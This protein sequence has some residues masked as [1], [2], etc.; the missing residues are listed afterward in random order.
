MN[1]HK[2]TSFILLICLLLLTACGSISGTPIVKSTHLPAGE[3]TYPSAATSID[4]VVEPEVSI[5]PTPRINRQVGQLILWHSWAGA[6][7]DALAEILADFIRIYPRL[8]VKTLYVSY[9]ELPV[10]YAEAV[11]AGGGPDIMLA[12]SWWLTDLVNAQVLQP[13]DGLIMPDMV[14]TYW[15]ATVDSMRRNGQLYGLPTHFEVLS[16]YY[17]RSL[18]TTEMLPT[19]TDQLTELARQSASYG[20]GL[21]LNLYH[22]SWALAAYGGELMD[23]DGKVILDQNDGATHFLDWMTE[24]NR[25]PSNHIDADYGALLERFKGWEFGFLVDGPW[26]AE[27]LRTAMGGSLGVA[28]L[29]WGPA[30]SPKPWLNADGFFVNPNINARAKEQAM[31]FAQH[32]TNAESGK[33][34]V[35]RAKR[36]PTAVP[37]PIHPE[38]EQVWGY[39][40]DMLIKVLNGVTDSRQAVVETTALINDV[41][42]K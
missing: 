32:L 4:E 21:Y 36:L 26:S 2:Y 14:G 18:I 33:I 24:F 15:P 35:E 25:I 1:V 19:N 34:M 41:N 20:T 23:D 40:G 16:L 28:Y 10:K 38:M 5:Q 37:M 17:N 29:P 7:A 9:D 12:P 6:D 39:G 27:E 31:L 42:G 8:R 13:L 3:A 11:Q 22:L 30:G